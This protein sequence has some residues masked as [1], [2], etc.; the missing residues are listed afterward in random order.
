VTITGLSGAEIGE[1][2]YF[3]SGVRGMVLVVEDKLVRALVFDNNTVVRR[4]EKV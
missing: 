2:L 3:G 1:R 4:T